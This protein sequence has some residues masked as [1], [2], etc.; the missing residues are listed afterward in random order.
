M[1]RPIW[2]GHLRLALVSC[3]VALYSAHHAEGTLHFNLL[4]PDTGNRI[5]MVTQDSETGDELAR[6]DLVK[7]YEAQK[8]NYIVVT[9]DE[10]DSVRVDSSDTIK[11]DKFLNA[12]ELDPVWFDSTYFMAPDGD[13]GID[14]Y[15]VLHE[16]FAQTGRVALS[17]VVIARRE[18]P[19]AIR[20]YGRGF[21]VHTLH[22][23]RDLNDPDPLFK[24]IPKKSSDR[25]MVGLA[26]QLIERQDGTY[27]PA[28]FE[29]R[30]ETRLR[31]LIE[32]KSK[33][34]KVK[35]PADKGPAKDNVVDLMAA[36]KRSLSGSVAEKAAPKGKKK[37]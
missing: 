17:R 3:P 14:V 34:R 9:E 30:Y 15:E 29:D 23:S 13:N 21:V 12:S 27:D 20:A 25:E 22:D 4:N 11:I 32:A 18:R 10:F 16:A 33:G 26:V 5:R 35:A 19:I 8:G 2:R 31:A 37:A 28:D 24:P 7:G 36:L 6:A 1:Q